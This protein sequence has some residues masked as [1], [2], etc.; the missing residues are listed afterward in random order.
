M[1]A[2][3]QALLVDKA[4]VRAASIEQEALSILPPKL[5]HGMQSGRRGVLQHKIRPWV[6]AEG[7]VVLFVQCL[8]A[9][10]GAAL[11][12]LQRVQDPDLSITHPM[13]ALRLERF[14]LRIRF[15]ICFLKK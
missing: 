10:N 6:P 12:H 11:H 15:S 7:P 2:W 14:G 13:S 3:G 1:L 8:L 9:Q 5:Q 4:A